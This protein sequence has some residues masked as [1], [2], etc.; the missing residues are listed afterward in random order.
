MCEKKIN[1]PAGKGRSQSQFQS[2]LQ[3]QLQ[4]AQSRL[5][6]W[7]KIH[8]LRGRS[9]HLREIE[10]EIEV[11]FEVEK[12]TSEVAPWGGEWEASEYRVQLPTPNFPLPTSPYFIPVC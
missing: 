3:P 5:R 8:L 10:I 7:L 12:T 6:I 2:Q 1:L 11:V 4:N 9:L